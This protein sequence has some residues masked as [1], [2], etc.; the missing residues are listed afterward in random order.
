MIIASPP[1]GSVDIAP[2]TAVT[3]SAVN[4]KLT[5]VTV[6]AADGTVVAGA[7]NAAGNTWTLTERLTFDQVYGFAI[8]ASE[9]NGTVT[10]T[11]GTISTVSPLKT[12]DARPIVAAEGGTFGVGQPVKIQF[13]GTVKNRAEAEKRMV[14]TTNRGHIDGCWGWLPD[15]ETPGG[16]SR[17][18]VHWRPKEFWPANTQVTA[19]MQLYGVDLGDGNWGARD[20]TLTFAIGRK[21]IAYADKDT[22]HVRVEEDDV[23]VRNY[24]ASYGR[25]DSGREIHSGIHV[26]EERIPTKKNGNAAPTHNMCNDAFAYC[27]VEVTWP[28]RINSNGEFIHENDNT[29]ASQGVRN[30][31]HG[32]INMST[33]NA[34][35][36]YERCLVGDPV[37]V[38]NTR[39]SMDEQD[40]NFDWIYD[41]VTWKERYS[42]L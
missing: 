32:C 28:V 11:E 3:L 27:G 4:G 18:Q 42:A 38:T 8:S 37:I 2:S 23:Q 17:S 36:F 34:K 31:S 9:A 35:D 26:I 39:A 24:P 30:V 25:A 33:A 16:A 19:T 10:S 22:F 12:L 21:L 41:Y 29:I 40:S 15:E 7:I 1:L 13:S 5:R 6:T 14:V 20:S